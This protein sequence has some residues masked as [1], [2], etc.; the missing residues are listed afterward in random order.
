MWMNP[1]TAT[2]QH[3]S[4]TALRNSSTA[5]LRA[6]SESPEIV[7]AIGRRIEA[8]PKKNRSAFITPSPIIPAFPWIM[9]KQTAASASCTKPLMYRRVSTESSRDSRVSFRLRRIIFRVN[10]RRTDLRIFGIGRDYDRFLL[11]KEGSF[12]LTAHIRKAAE[13]AFRS[14]EANLEF[15]VIELYRLSDL[16]LEP[17]GI[18]HP[19]KLWRPCELHN[20][21]AMPT[22]CNIHHPD[23]L[24]FERIMVPLG[25]LKLRECMEYGFKTR[26]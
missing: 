7:R 9:R 1:S 12:T 13:C 3:A 23:H 16:L 6:K 21:R 15:F 24:L 17:W 18:A 8:P 2:R 4:P 26:G 5:S 11:F 19:T 20:H 22:I 25:G 14:I 10:L